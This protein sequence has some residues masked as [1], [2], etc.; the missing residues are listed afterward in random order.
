MLKRNLYNN[1]IKLLIMILNNFYGIFVP[2]FQSNIF[3]A[4]EN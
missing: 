2:G 3:F 1:I 4:I